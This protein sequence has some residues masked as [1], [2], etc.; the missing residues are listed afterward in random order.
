MAE[1]DEDDLALI[2]AQMIAR[3]QSLNDDIDLTLLSRNDLAT[4]KGP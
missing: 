3:K 1:F 2:K 4:R